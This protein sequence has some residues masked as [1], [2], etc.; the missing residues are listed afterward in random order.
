MTSLTRAQC[1]LRHKDN[2]VITSVA[3]IFWKA[4][5]NMIELLLLSAVF[6]CYYTIENLIDYL[7]FPGQEKLFNSI[8]AGNKTIVFMIDD[9]LS[10][11]DLRAFYVLFLTNA[12]K[13]NEFY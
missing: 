10:H 1:Q 7:I 13:Q 4:I 3:K 6:L 12:S 2:D 11:F 8:R 5:F 9:Y